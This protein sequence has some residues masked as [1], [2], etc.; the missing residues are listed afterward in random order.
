[1]SFSFVGGA[2]VPV[3]LVFVLDSSASLGASNWGLVKTLAANI[4]GNFDVSSTGTRFEFYRF[5]PMRIVLS[6]I[7][8]FLLV[9]LF[10]FN[11]PHVIVR[12]GLFL[13]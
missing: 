7:L 4:V 9:I 8:D 1:M 12:M 2:G 6:I 3:D 5:D 10:L 13:V 11:R